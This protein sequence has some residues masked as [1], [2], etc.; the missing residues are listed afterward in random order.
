MTTPSTPP[1][2]G[3]RSPHL[4]RRLLGEHVARYWGKLA[5]AMLFMAMVAAATAATAKLIEP[6]LDEVFGARDASRLGLIAAAVLATFVVKSLAMYGHAVLM[7]RVGLR[8]VADMQ[9]RLMRHLL[10]ADL[11]FFHRNPSATLVSRF[12]NDA[13]MLKAAVSTTLTGIGRDVATLLALIGVM[14]WQDWLLALIVFAAF[15]LAGWPAQKLGRLM[16]KLSKRTQVE[17]GQFMA[18]LGQTFQGIRQVK[19]C[20]GEGREAERGAGA[21]E[22]LFRLSDKAGRNRALNLPVTEAL[23]GI[24]IT[25]SIYYGGTM[26]MSGARTTGEFFSFV[27]ALLLAYEPV[28]RLAQMNSAL[29]EGLAA[30]ERLYEMLDTRPAITD[31]PGAGALRPTGGE[32]RIEGVRFA[33]DGAGAAALNGIDLTVP[34]GRTVALVGPSGAGKSTLLNLIPRFYDVEAGRILIDGQDV[35]AVTLASL[36]DALALV[37]QDVTIFDDSLRANI[38]YG[39]PGASDAEIEA[40]ARA[41]AAHDFITALPAGYDSRAG[42]HG[43]SL[44]GGQRQRIAIARAILRDAPILLLDEATS[45]LDSESEKLVQDA[46]DRLMR[47]RTVLVIAHRL[48]T[49]VKADQIVVIDGGRIVEAGSHAALM[50]QGGLYA[51]L[52][53]LQSAA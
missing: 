45:A 3:A 13:N 33:Y 1:A 6:V 27:T 2:G 34:A 38:A 40:A 35:R 46:L 48:S 29:Q 30:A 43:V 37:S 41:A 20:N 12:T 4:V 36:R 50:A 16:R 9:H 22:E 21:I 25:A 11:A 17:T 24:A 10:A 52:Q 49:V 28:K 31:A 39:R 44:S 53:S 14:F 8:I 18:L 32:I 42:E 15:P 26:V 19:A 51:R 7:N 5:L 47:G 23:G